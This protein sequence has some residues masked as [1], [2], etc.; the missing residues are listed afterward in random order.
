MDI[1]KEF[2]EDTRNEFYSGRPVKA[3][4]YALR[5]YGIYDMQDAVVDRCVTDEECKDGCRFGV[6]VRYNDNVYWVD[7]SDC[8]LV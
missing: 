2:R 1:F 8:E 7:P 3:K 6:M 5:K 4:I